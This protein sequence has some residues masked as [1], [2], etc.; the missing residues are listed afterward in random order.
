MRPILRQPPVDCPNEEI[1]I[2]DEVQRRRSSDRSQWIRWTAGI[3]LSALGF[4]TAVLIGRVSNHGERLVATENDI[5][6]LKEV[7]K[8]IKAR[9]KEVHEDE[10]KWRT[11]MEEKLDRLVERRR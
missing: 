3:I 10:W 1:C 11:R 7:D 9:E 5:S 8:E 4:C 6:T 2:E